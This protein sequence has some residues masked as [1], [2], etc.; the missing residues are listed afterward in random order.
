MSKN[1]KYYHS[2]VQVEDINFQPV[3]GY[4]VKPLKY[5]I[6]EFNESNNINYKLQLSYKLP[7]E[8][9]HNCRFCQNRIIYPHSKLKCHKDNSISV[10]KPSIEKRIINGKEYFLSCC[11]KCLLDHFKKDPP[12]SPKY[13]TMKG[14]RFGAYVYGYS[15]EEYKK[16]ASMTV[17]VTEKSMIRKWGKNE[18]LKRWKK[19]CN[20]HRYIASKKYFIDK[21]GKEEG[22]KKYHDGRAVTLELCIKRHG[23]E[24]GQK[25]WD[26]YI[27]LQ[28]I[29]KSQQYMVDKFGIE[30]TK[31]INQSKA[32]TIE[33]FIKKYGEEK[34]I[35]KYNKVMNRMINFYSNIS[36]K[37]FNELDS[38]ISNKFNLTTYYAT[39]NGEYGVML[40]D[41]QYVKLDYFI[42][43][44][45]ICIEFNGTKFHADSRYYNDKDHPN[46]FNK[47]L[48][49]K[50][51]R[52]NDIKRYNKLEKEKGIKTYII[53]ES[54]YNEN[55][56]IEN[57]ITNTLNIK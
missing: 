11:E 48:S 26:N 10:E 19:Y 5:I 40:S 50:E 16:L 47:E 36:Q 41:N 30:K 25:I 4:D 9:F 33:N 22:I 17:A 6:K 57:Y 18:G 13:Y 39:K 55:F 7:N 15:E 20:K 14:N 3:L 12:K 27:K 1:N 29:T 54:D 52:E 51:I 8:L 43:E 46:P 42:K 31:Q 35:K 45:N 53:W 44:K 34:G 28:K 37:C 2:E 23:K 56:D 49:A 32:I 21:Y 24:E 38:I